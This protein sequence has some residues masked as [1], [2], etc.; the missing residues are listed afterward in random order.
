MILES[1]SREEL[2]SKLGLISDDGSLSERGLADLIRSPLFRWGLSR[3]SSLLRY[4]RDQVKAVGVVDWKLQ[5][6]ARVLKRLVGLG[7]CAEV[8]IGYDRYIA[9]ARATW[10][11]TG[12]ES[13]ALLG[14]ARRPE[15]VPE[16]ILDSSGRDIVRRILVRNDQDRAA[17]RA[18]GIQENSIDEWLQPYKYLTHAARRKGHPVRSD[19]LSVAEFWELLVS[20][21]GDR[22]LPL[23]VDA[24]VRAVV[25]EPGGYFGPWNATSCEGRWSDATPDGVWCAYR[26][27]YGEQHWHPMV[28][29]AHGEQR[30]ALD[31]Y[32][33]DEWRWALLGRGCSN[34]AGEQIERRDGH[35]RL[36]FPGPEQLIA[37]MDILGPR[38][39]AWTWAVSEAAADP[40][41]VLMKSR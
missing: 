33:H 27:G 36:S 18:A 2:R 31:L 10:I 4:A 38:S 29:A 34:G 37:A 6:L 19:K 26:R 28:L 13:A 15:G 17:L 1:M 11:R 7:E 35:T 3:R 12:R 25:G 30:R 8:L 21:L 41:R 16:Q 24:D 32:D 20:E 39:D 5:S 22:G 40:W 23:S 9:P 14:A